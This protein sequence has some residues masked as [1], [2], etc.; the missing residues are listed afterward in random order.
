MRVAV[1]GADTPL[2]RE[3]VS[4]L[5][6]RGHSATAV[7]E[8][9]A[10]VP[11]EW[12]GRITLRVGAPT[13]AA[14][15]D[16][17][18]AENDVVVDA[19]GDC[20][21]GTAVARSV[22]ATRHIVASMERHGRFRY[23]GLRPDVLLRPSRLRFP[24]ASSLRLLA[25]GCSPR[26][27]RD[28]MGAFEAVARSRLS[29]TVVRCPGM[30]DGPPRGVRHVGMTHRDAVGSSLTRTDAARFLSALVLETRYICA[31]PAISN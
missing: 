11:S 3:V 25:L 13:D 20:R 4:D 8:D 26:T 2:G 6:F 5:V 30:K 10:Q 23:I 22:A 1:F 9:P 7:V 29:W 16:A 27:R 28:A 24:W 15:V 17:V 14:L 19:L 21:G 12:A 18:V 31:A